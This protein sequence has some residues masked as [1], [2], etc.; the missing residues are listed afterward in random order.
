MRQVLILTGVVVLLLVLGEVSIRLIEEGGWPLW[1]VTTLILAVCV[2][3]G[4]ILFFL[5]YYFETKW[6][7]FAGLM[8][9]CENIIPFGGRIN[10]LILGIAGIAAG[11]LAIV[12]LLED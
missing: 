1:K 3:I 12:K 7:G 6:R 5:S 9:V 8:W 2:L 10:A 11:V 4:G